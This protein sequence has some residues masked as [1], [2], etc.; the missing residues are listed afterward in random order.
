[1]EQTA[2]AGGLRISQD[3]YALVRGVFDV[4]VQQP[5]TVKGIDEPI[6]SY[7]VQRAK[8]RA[9]RLP[10]RG[11]EGVAT[12]MIGR[13]AELER[14]QAAFKALMQPG[15]GLQ[16][17]TVVGEAGVGKSR[18]L[19]EF[20]HWAEARPESFFVFQ[21]R[22]VP[23]TQGHAYGLLRELFAWRWQID[24]GDAMALA[25]SKL[26]AGL[27]PLFIAD[28]GELE[29][30]AHAHLLGQLIGLDYAD[31]PH[32][33]GIKDDGRQIRNRGL[34]AAAQVL[35]R[36]AAQGGS[37]LVIYL[38]DLH[39][40]D[41]ASLDFIDVLAQVN[42]DVPM[43]LIGLARPT[44]FERR[45]HADPAHLAPNMQ[46]IGLHALD[47][48]VS[49]Q[50]A[51]ELLKKLPEIPAA[52]RELITGG[53]D[54]NPFYM[55]ELV[56]MLVD[57]GTIRTRGEHWSLDGDKLLSLKAPPTLTG[58][59]QARLDGLPPAER[60]ALQLASVIGLNFWDAALAHIEAA[61]AA[62]LKPL[63][64]RELVNL[65]EAGSSADEV[66]EYAFAH[67]ILHQ[68]T[69]DTVL[70]RTRRAA[71]AKTAHWLAECSGTRA[72]GLLGAAAEHYEQADEPARAA[73]FYT[74]AAEH[75]ASTFANEAVL[76]YAARALKLAAPGDHATRWRLHAARE[77]TLDLLGRRA[78]QLQD[79]QALEAQAE[80]LND[81][82]RRADAA[83]RHAIFG[84]RIGEFKAGEAD[85]Q[86]AVELATDVGDEEL[87]LLATRA[88]A[89]A[90]ASGGDA[91]AGRAIAEMALAR[92]QTLG[93]LL[94]QARLANAASICA[95][96]QGDTVATLRHVELGLAVSRQRGDRLGEAHALGNIGIAYVGLGDFAG[97]CRHLEQALRL[98]RALG[99][100]APQGTNL[101]VLSD[102]ARQRGDD[103]LALTQAEA[104]V[105]ICSEVDSPVHLCDALVMLGNAELGLGRHA[106]SSAAF[107]RSEAVAR[108][109]GSLRQRVNALEAQARLALACGDGPHALAVA[110]RL[111]NE[112]GLGEG[113][114]LEAPAEGHADAL[115]G[116]E[117][118]RLYL[119]LHQV[120]S[121]AG[122]ARATAA[123]AEAHRCLQADAGAI[124][125]AALRHA[126]LNN[127]TEHREIAALWAKRAKGAATPT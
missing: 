40:A 74:R 113:G 105:A 117:K 115:D 45:P 84:I 36:I 64:Q 79:I 103:A 55:E 28:E 85:A 126:Y 15:A 121:H 108:T 35:R 5:L 68:V 2:P 65:K 95:D 41:D 10:S 116:N 24:D 110:A 19:D 123:L 20:R 100:R 127:I 53:A 7:L 67:Q 17:L 32:I 12:R 81:D 8:P 114:A 76:D 75:A 94:A 59:L 120:W 88:R 89:I 78:A 83:V 50:L 80:A 86:R 38:D 77:R 30:Q 22:A 49:R 90:V 31:S 70:K 60:H 9:F 119:T 73:E 34:H 11:I 25:R 29:A 57:Q 98:N 66:R 51:N 69:Y 14:L 42:R 56:K 111:L 13:D 104:A 63:A 21:A 112:A 118:P 48:G 6:V 71:H 124:T 58:V 82:W 46:R 1:M 109:I 101:A 61:A 26:E 102:I 87:A 27:T 93:S 52:L 54:G 23:Q 72:K 106:A 99:N 39:W 47:K 62:A 33:R 91:G 125:D 4:E 3:T 92:A 122:D 43:L 97:A 44:L 107:E 18:L 16:R 96:L 37:P